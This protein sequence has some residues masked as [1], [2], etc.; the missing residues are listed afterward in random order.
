MCIQIEPAGA[1]V[2]FDL[3]WAEALVLLDFPARVDRNGRPDIQDLAEPLIFWHL[4]NVLERAF[5]RPTATEYS[6]R[7][8]SA[9][10]AVRC[11]A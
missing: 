10:E 8:A 4:F 3:T 7:D 11:S 9:R 2:T 1:N 5:P 6:E